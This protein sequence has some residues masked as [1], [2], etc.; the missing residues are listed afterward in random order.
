[1]HLGSDV[2]VPDLAGW[3]RARLPSLP[4][5]A[6]IATAPDWVCEVLSPATRTYDLTEKRD[7][8]AERGVE[9]LWLI[10]P[11]ARTLEVFRCS[12]G[13]WTLISALHDDA[14]VRL[15]PFDAVAFSLSGLW[16]D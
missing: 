16:T 10:D 3:R 7:I 12:D 14:E 5:E 4:S 1:M 13:A 15:P 11:Q 9:H 8:H 2:L 6:H